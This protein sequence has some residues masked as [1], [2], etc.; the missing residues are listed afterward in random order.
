VAFAIGENKLTYLGAADPVLSSYE[1]A[2]LDRDVS[3]D[4][5]GR[6]K[7]Y[8]LEQFDAVDLDDLR[9]ASDVDWDSV[10]WGDLQDG[11]VMLNKHRFKVVKDRPQN[12]IQY[13]NLGTSMM[14][15]VQISHRPPW[16]P[17]LSTR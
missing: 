2:G 17:L 13:S 5:L 14:E 7:A 12:S 11:C 3:F 9:R 16:N 1:A 6:F 8:G 4:R 10:E 15:H